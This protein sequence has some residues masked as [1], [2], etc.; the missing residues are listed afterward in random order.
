M[1]KDDVAKQK[2]DQIKRKVF[3]GGLNKKTNEVT[4]EQYFSKFGEIEDILIN[5]DIANNSSKGCAFLLFK[6][7]EVAKELIQSKQVHIID[8][9]YVEVK[10]CYEKSKSKALKEEKKL[11]A[12]QGENL[13]FMNML[14][15]SA[16][17]NMGHMMNQFMGN[18]MGGFSGMNQ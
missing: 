18:F 17:M 16:G 12:Q 15:S 13:L 9:K 11:K 3:L 2:S 6:K 14:Q 8:G 1:N 5:R 7:A 10:K 4:L